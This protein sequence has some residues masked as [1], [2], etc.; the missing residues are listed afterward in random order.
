MIMPRSRKLFALEFVES[1]WKKRVLVSGAGEKYNPERHF[2]PLEE[3][4]YLEEALKGVPYGTFR[5]DVP[6]EM[7]NLL[8]NGYKDENDT[9]WT[10]FFAYWKDQEGHAFL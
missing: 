2:L 7:T 5:T 10:S 3:S 6:E 8:E 1:T 4:D 9:V